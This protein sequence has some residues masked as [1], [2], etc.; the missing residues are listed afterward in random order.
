MH[1]RQRELAL[2]FA[3]RAELV[4][5]L[6][7]ELRES[8]LPRADELELP[9]DEW[10]RRVDD[11]RPLGVAR[12][13]VPLAAQHLPRLLDLGEREQLLEREAEQVA[14][15]E[16]L[17]QARDVGLAIEA[18]RAFRARRRRAEQSELLVVA[19]RAS[20]DADALGDLA[21][22]VVA[23]LSYVLT[24]PPLDRL[25]ACR[26]RRRA[27]STWWYLPPR[28]SEATAA[29]RQRAIANTNA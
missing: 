4:R 14:E 29:T 23:L 3:Q 7:A 8:L 18:M 1:E 5:Q 6:V 10:D 20:R 15:P 19:D 26:A 22:P 16:E 12:V 24:P 13:I 17:P 25:D 28:S 21:D 27:G 9:L 2:T 11:P